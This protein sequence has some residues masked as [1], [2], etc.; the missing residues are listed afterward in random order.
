MNT[1]N[2][3]TNYLLELAK[4]HRIL[5]YPVLA[6]IA[7][8]SVFSYFFNWSTGAGKRVVAVVMV[9]V[10]LVSQSYFLTSS[11]TEITDD[12]GNYGEGNIVATEVS[13]EDSEE[14]SDTTTQVEE[15]DISA[16]EENTQP[17]SLLGNPSTT[18]NTDSVQIVLSYVDADGN[19]AVSTGVSAYASLNSEGNVYDLG[20]VR[21]TLKAAVDG[22]TQECYKFSGL[23]MDAHCSVSYIDSLPVD[24]PYIT[25]YNG[26]KSMV[27]YCLREV[28]QYKVTFV[29]SPLLEGSETVTYQTEVGGTTASNPAVIKVDATGSPSG[30]TGTFK[31]SGLARHGYQVQMPEVS[32]NGVAVKESDGAYTI[33]LNG[34]SSPERTITLKWSGEPY[35]IRYCH[36]KQGDAT[37]TDSDYTV[38]NLIYG[39]TGNWYSKTQAGA[40]DYVGYNF[41]GWTFNGTSYAVGGVI[42][43]AEHAALYAAAK[44]G[45][46]TL[47]PRYSKADLVLEDTELSFQYGVKQSETIKVHYNYTDEA[48]DNC[49]SL[50]YTVDEG[51]KTALGTVGINVTSDADG[52]YLKTEGPT[53]TTLTTSQKITFSVTDGL[54]DASMLTS[55]NVTI[56][57]KP[58][59]V[60]VEIPDNWKTKIYNGNTKVNDTFSKT[61]PTGSLDLNNR[62]ITVNVTGTIS[63]DSKDAGTNK[64]ITMT[65]CELNLDSQFKDCYVLEGDGGTI[66]ITGCTIK[67]KAIVV[68]TTSSVDKIR[69]GESTPSNSVFDT[70]ISEGFEWATGDDIQA[71]GEITY[72]LRPTRDTDEEK[73]KPG[74]YKVV[75]SFGADSNYEAQVYNEN[76]ATITVVEEAPTLGGNYTITGVKNGDW[77][78]GQA[79]VITPIQS[80]DLLGGG[81]DQV[82]ISTDGGT[83]WTQW[84]DRVNLPSVEKGKS[85]KIQLGYKGTG[86]VTSVG[87]LSANYDAEAPEY[88][89]YSFT[90]NEDTSYDW[91]LDK[92]LNN[93]GFYFPGY[94]G[95]LSFGTYIKS[96]IKIKVRFE[97]SVSGLSVLNYGIYSSDLTDTTTFEDGVACIELNQSLVQDGVG[98]IIC[99]AVDKAGNKSDLILLRPKDN[100]NDAY[101]WSVEAKEPSQNVLSVTYGDKN[102]GVRGPVASSSGIYYRNCVAQAHVVDNESG[103]KNVKWY[104]NGELVATQ[105]PEGTKE[106]GTPKLSDKKTVSGDFSFGDNDIFASDTSAYTI[107][108]VVEDNAG[109]EKESNAVVFL[110]DNDAPDVHV[111][112]EEDVNKW[113]SD[114]VITFTT[115]DAIS[116]VAY[117][118]VVKEDGSVTN[119]SLE[120]PDEDGKY[121]GSFYVTGK[122]KYTVKVADVAGNVKEVTFNV[123]NISKEVPECPT[124]SVSPAEGT[125]ENGNPVEEYWYNSTS[126]APVITIG[127]VTKTTDNTPVET[128]Y[129]HYK[130]NETAYDDVLIPSDCTEKQISIASGDDAIHYFEYWSVSA[131]GVKCEDAKVHKAI[132]RYD[133]SSPTVTV[134]NVPEESS[135]SSVMI[136]FTVKDEVSGVNPDTIKVLRNGKEIESAIKQ[137]ETGYVGTFL[138]KETGNYEVAAADIAGNEATVA[139]F[140]PMSMVVNPIGSISESKA[141]LSAKVYKGTADISAAPVLSIRKETDTDYTESSNT[142]AVK[143]KDGNW[144][145]STV[146]EQLEENTTYVYKIRAVSDMNEVLEYEG[147]LRTSSVTQEGGEVRGTA[148]Y[149]AGAVIPAWNENGTV[150]VGI[151][152]GSICI[153]ATTINAGDSFAFKNIPDGTYTVV[154]TDGVYKKTMSITLDNHVIVKP[155][156]TI[157]LILSGQ[158]TSIILETPDTP[159]ITVDNMDS[160]FIYDNV[161]NFTDADRALIEANG[162]VEF[163]LYAALTTVVDVSQ[164]E[165]AV[166]QR[167]GSDGKIVAKY[168][169]LTLEKITTD[170]A[171]NVIRTQVSELSNGASIIIT[172]PLGDLAGKN[173]IE[174]VRV[175]DGAGGLEGYRY[176]TDM[177]SNPNTFTF[178]SSKFSTYAILYSPETGEESTTEN[179]GNST[180]NSNGGNASN[181]NPSNTNKTQTGVTS[182]SFGVVSSG[183]GQAKTGDA[184]PIMVMFLLMTMSLGGVATVVTLRRKMH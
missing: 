112:Y 162:T 127:N 88:K 3:L 113:T 125:D 36:K 39:E 172:V 173:G 37:I 96:T 47:Y 75:P 105:Y 106:D 136:R 35:E 78:V 48:R 63:Y 12:S 175:H 8:I 166:I 159:K 117:A 9:L 99:Q 135:G 168:L 84:S 16:F 29:N 149:P 180:E 126:G 91:D 15:Q 128:Y 81:Y 65:G 165:L 41:E 2:R 19:N 169:S 137:T 161:V 86:A 118:V 83:T 71:L 49:A 115:S 44:T 5:T 155:S 51:T 50:T 58:Q 119:V 76:L 57:I 160:I 60:R 79:P 1:K 33:T 93:G 17:A 102:G 97:D 164:D 140:T 150:V 101:E 7:L 152:D 80:A 158:N 163:R 10:M 107:K 89:G 114:E 104:V 42:S 153:A 120:N 74:S 182:T 28:A 61:V 121:S 69:T 53:D 108:A 40:E 31:I 70:I 73:L 145:V 151:F 177:D 45:T 30:K 176:E 21:S 142:I 146:F 66:R 6:L 77:Y 110:A 27:V 85:V 116:G 72:S 167:V 184:S 62:P 181:Q 156:Q 122:G 141:T 129:R 100:T 54:D 109:N 154:A 131:S 148:G 95:I 55:Q 139:G 13:S 174:I 87:T 144:S 56:V 92:T 178:S 98:K 32:D 94:G 147:Y 133:G 138:V 67:K 18:A 52:I 4:K 143:D 11:A 90:V 134:E 171:G 22:Y 46:V 23:Y 111:N 64:V 82:R 157:S 170:A 132:V 14:D 38:Q 124:F 123:Q 43:A 103:I 34:S 59:T 26:A 24:S 183:S 179:N 20:A 68:N 130:N 25:E